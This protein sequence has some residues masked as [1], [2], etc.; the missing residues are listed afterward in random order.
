[1]HRVNFRQGKS[2]LSFNLSDNA[3]DKLS[4]ATNFA[5]ANVVFHQYARHVPED[6]RLGCWDQVDLDAALLEDAIDDPDNYAP[7]P[8]QL[9]EIAE[10]NRA[11]RAR[12]G[13][14]GCPLF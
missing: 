9:A 2:N 10:Q 11:V 4:R 3:F 8:G 13:E 1:M 6:Y 7:T 14:D 5:V 12:Y